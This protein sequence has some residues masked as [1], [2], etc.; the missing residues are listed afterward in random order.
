MASIW[1]LFVT[2]GID[3]SGFDKGIGDAEKRADKSGSAI[4][5][6][7]SRVGGSIVMGGLAAAG[8]GVAALGGFLAS[9]VGPASDL[10]ETISKVGVV[11][12][13]Q[14]DSVLAF[15]QNA[16]S[17][18]GLSENAALSAAGTYGN[19][20]RSMGM[21][22][23]ASASMSTGLVQLAGDLA[24]FNNLDPTDVLDKLRAGLTGETEPL[25]S[26]G[27]NLNATAVAA[28]AL[29]MGLVDST[30]DTLAVAD[31]QNKLDKAVKAT[32]DAARMYGPTSQKAKD[33]AIAEA[34]AQE[35][36]DKAMAGSTGELSAAAKAQA[37]YALVMEQTSLAQGDFARTSD[38]LANQQRIMA[39]N[40]E[41]TKAQVGTAILPLM[42]TLSS[43][44][45]GLF[46]DP[47]F[48]AG[49]Q[50]FIAGLT[51][52]VNTV[53]TG[54]P[55]VLAWFQNAF[56]WL[57][58][59]Q[60]V[61]IG[62]LAAIGVA[63]GAFVYTVV[64]PALG[65]LIVAF[66]PV[67]LIMAAVGV[68][69]FLLYQAWTTNFGGI[70]EKTATVIE[71]IKTNVAAFIAAVQAWWT[72]H[73]EQV[74]AIVNALWDGVVTIFNNFVKTIKDYQELFGLAFSGKW[75]E[76]GEKLR[77]MWDET[78]EKIKTGLSTAWEN[79][80]TVVSEGVDNIKSW[81]TSVDWGQVGNQIIQGIANGISAGAKAVA[82]A[83]KKAA[84][85]AL[86]AAKGFLGIESP[87][88]VFAAVGMN[89]S[90][91]MAEGI[92]GGA[93]MVEYAI[94]DVSGRAAGAAAGNTSTVTN[95]WNM[96]IYTTQ[97]PQ[98]VQNGI[99]LAQLMGG[100]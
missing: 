30:V 72:A 83:A 35:A 71:W 69:A 63:V 68:A 91:G 54:F 27:V 28:K 80:K 76:F 86:D 37:T 61:M 41:N 10:N 62:I 85:A 50:N 84:Q 34:K 45:N 2:L 60:G 1:D 14:A 36:L 31:A 20:F 26:L 8:A 17:S 44:I 49:L 9:S 21:T 40:W 23:T 96:P 43:T 3:T 98:V 33:A 58:E 66:A 13:D 18:L 65:S 94:Q 15:G 75:R 25:K 59:N 70:Q 100:A 74:K 46:S 51:N 39:A 29:S 90:A 6:N 24:S 11:F 67:L 53:I 48:Q 79:I 32:N 42:T 97:S 12:G 81:F 47:A 16:A 57:Q 19:L 52:L 5:S 92:M 64:L 55:Q 73:G 38:G 4:V 56:G 95:N 87:S 88:K 99:E 22:S 93:G 82:D 89:I 78:W 77:E 7:L